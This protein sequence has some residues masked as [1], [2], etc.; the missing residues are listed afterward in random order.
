MF[1][2][3]P[4]KKNKNKTKTKKHMKSL[5]ELKKK[6]DTFLT[7]NVEYVIVIFW[8]GLRRYIYTHICVNHIFSMETLR[9]C[10]KT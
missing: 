10:I 5:K 7:Q 8:L 6:K 9:V 4:F 1:I 2:E 3:V